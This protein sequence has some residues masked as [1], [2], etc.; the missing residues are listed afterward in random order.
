MKLNQPRR[1]DEEK[2]IDDEKIS[3][4]RLQGKT[5]RQIAKEVGLSK[6]EVTKTLSRLRADWRRR[7]KESTDRHITESVA[8]LLRTMDRAWIAYDNSIGPH[9]KQTQ[10]TIAGAVAETSV[11]TEELNGDPRYLTIVLDCEKQLRGL[12]GLDAPT[13]T[14][15]STPDNKPL[16]FSWAKEPEEP[17]PEQPSE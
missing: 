5:H 11:Q 1:G 3:T 7:A 16:Q 15:L 9:E 12:L 2:A 17:P 6:A 10:K 14:E 13:K 4:L 8:R